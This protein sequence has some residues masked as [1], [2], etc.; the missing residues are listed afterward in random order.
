M[1]YITFDFYVTGNVRQSV[2]LEPEFSE[3]TT[4]D[5][6]DGFRRGVYMTTVGHVFNMPTSVIRASDLKRVATIMDSE[7]LDD[8]HLSDFEEVNQDE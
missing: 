3:L 1:S 6:I 7:P 8:I 4:A 5:L 2:H